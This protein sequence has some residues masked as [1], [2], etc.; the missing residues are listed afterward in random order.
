MCA[1]LSLAARG[2]ARATGWLNRVAAVVF[3]LIAIKLVL[4]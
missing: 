1:A 2:L 3:G 4:D